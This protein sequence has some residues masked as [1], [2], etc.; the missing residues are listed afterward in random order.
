[1]CVATDTVIHFGFQQGF[2]LFLHMSA[3]Y[4][5]QRGH[6]ELKGD[7]FFL[8]GLIIFLLHVFIPFRMRQQRIIAFLLDTL[9]NRQ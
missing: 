4:P 1:M 2:G 7:M 8:Q 5:D 3:V 6:I 9:Q